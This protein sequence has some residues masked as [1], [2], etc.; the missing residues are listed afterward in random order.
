MAHAPAAGQKQLGKTQEAWPQA[1]PHEQPHATFHTCALMPTGTGA[2]TSRLTGG[3]AG[4][5]GDRLRPPCTFDSPP[6][7]ACCSGGA[8]PATLHVG[9]RGMG[10]GQSRGGEVRGQI[11]TS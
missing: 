1:A 10:R 9:R 3:E 4:C 6:K 8:I 11:W 2:C 5:A 7:R